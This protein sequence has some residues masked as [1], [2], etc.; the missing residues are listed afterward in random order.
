MKTRT[1]FVAVEGWKLDQASR[2]IGRMMEGDLRRGLGREARH[3][4]G[5]WR[6]VSKFK[7]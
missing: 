5:T 1:V 2:S 4:G 3:D 7:L 6:R